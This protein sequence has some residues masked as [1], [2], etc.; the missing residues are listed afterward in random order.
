MLNKIPGNMWSLAQFQQYLERK[1]GKKQ[2]SP[3]KDSPEVTPEK[4][5][6]QNEASDFGEASGAADGNIN[7]EEIWD[8]KYY[9]QAKE[10]V[11]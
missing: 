1:S 2:S 4:V 3:K 8:T 11:I 5:N 7:G 9:P 10:I 6:T